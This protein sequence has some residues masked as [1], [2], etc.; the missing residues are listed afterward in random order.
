MRI[1][2][3]KPTKLAGCIVVVPKVFADPRGWFF[4]S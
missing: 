2:E 3:F 4:E 1:V